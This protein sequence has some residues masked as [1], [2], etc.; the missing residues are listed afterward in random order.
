MG[1]NV[2][3]DQLTSDPA[4]AHQMP[5]PHPHAPLEIKFLKFT[6]VGSR[7]LCGLQIWLH[8]ITHLPHPRIGTYHGLHL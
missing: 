5:T 3:Y 6:S 8:Q 7:I 2:K 1:E 4:N